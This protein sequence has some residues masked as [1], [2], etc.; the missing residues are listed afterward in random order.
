MENPSKI[1]ISRAEQEVQMSGWIAAAFSRGNCSGK[2]SK[3]T[4]SKYT[5]KGSKCQVA[6]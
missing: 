4:T 6:Y 1:L 3:Y 2:T 5:I